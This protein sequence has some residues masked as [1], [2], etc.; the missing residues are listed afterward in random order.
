MSQQRT[1]QSFQERS[2]GKDVRTSNIVAAK[3]SASND[4]RRPNFNPYDTCSEQML[5]IKAV[6]TY[7]HLDLLLLMYM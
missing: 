4:G 3:V 5:S 2:K 6:T 7:H 1:G